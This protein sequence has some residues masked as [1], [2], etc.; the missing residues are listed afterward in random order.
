M[1]YIV[2]EQ[3]FGDSQY[4]RGDEREVALKEDVQQLKKYHLIADTDSEE[5][6]A[7]I[8][9]KAKKVTTFA[10]AKPDEAKAA[11]EKAKAEA[12]AEAAEKAKADA[13][14]AEKAKAEAEAAEKAKQKSATK[15]A[16]AETPK[17][18]TAVDTTD[19]QD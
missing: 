17:T 18:T 10:N 15:K 11:A 5:A 9:D 12:E 13:E 3:H 16:K 14:A 1:K 19:Q 8:A 2:I 4:Y 6:K 7:A